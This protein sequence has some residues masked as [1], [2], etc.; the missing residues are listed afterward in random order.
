M[1]PRGVLVV[2]LSV[3]SIVPEDADRGRGVSVDVST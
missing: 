3:R 1:V 2:T